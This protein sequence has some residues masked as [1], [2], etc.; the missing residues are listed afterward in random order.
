MRSETDDGRDAILTQLYRPSYFGEI[1]L[2]RIGKL[3][4]YAT[5]VSAVGVV[6]LLYVGFTQTIQTLLGINC[7][8]QSN[9]IGGLSKS[10]DGM[11][12]T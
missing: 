9:G 6:E 2:I 4:K 10:D 7:I 12:L 3:Y 11:L 5:S 8:T 1:G